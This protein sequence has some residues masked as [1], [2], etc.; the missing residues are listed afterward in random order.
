M[1]RKM[2]NKLIDFLTYIL[3]L[4]VVLFFIYKMQWFSEINGKW[5]YPKNDPRFYWQGVYGFLKGNGTF[6]DLSRGLLMVSAGC[7]LLVFS[8]ILFLRPKARLY[9][10]WFTS[11]LLSTIVFCDLI[12]FRYF[13]DLTSV[14]L[15]N[16]I[17][18]VSSLT[19]SIGE[20]FSKEELLLF[21][22]SILLIPFLVLVPLIYRK[23]EKFLSKTGLV[24]GVSLFSLGIYF[25]YY[26][27]NK[28]ITSGGGYLFEKRFS[29][30]RV[31][32]VLGLLGYHGYDIKVYAESILS[33]KKFSKEEEKNIKDLL[34]TK[35]KSRSFST[36]LKG[37]AKGKNVIIV[38][39]ESMQS[40][41]IDRSINRQ[42]ITP[43][44]NKLKNEMFWFPNIY[45]VSW[46]GRTSD[47]EFLMNTSLHPLLT[48]SVYMKHPSNT[49]DALP[50]I[51]R[52]N[53]YDTAAFHPYKGGFW[54]RNTVYNHFGFNHFYTEKDF[55]G[56]VVGWAVNDKDFFLESVE[57][58]K[59]LKKPFQA[60]MIALTN[61]HP[62]VIPEKY[63]NLNTAGY[64]E[65][66]FQNYLNGVHFVDEAVGIF[67][68]QLKKEGLWESSVVV[69]YGDH[70]NALMT[71]NGDMMKFLKS[72]SPDFN[73]VVQYKFTEG[74]PLFIHVPLQR[75]SV[76]AKTG[77]QI[78]FAPTLL[79]LLGINKNPLY[80]LGGNLLNKE[81]GQAVQRV[82]SFMND[83]YLYIAPNEGQANSSS[84]YSLKTNK[85]IN[86]SACEKDL[87]EVHQELEISDLLIQQD[88]IKQ[89][90][91]QK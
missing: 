43:H 30:E 64:N 16:Q 25:T 83:D 13:D 8:W 88:G 31:Y 28:W 47:A 19:E 11:T 59:R 21:A 68:D 67:V 86:L 69:F 40:F 42:E 73:P 49:Y 32:G 55:T 71:E 3:F 27:I 76:V 54:N 15:L 72:K 37:I 46:Q 65:K 4:F 77:S 36:P 63:K 7:V 62:Y 17:G 41:A 5:F 70:D 79:H 82:G 51:L 24:V 20:L 61:H 48:G 81:K 34:R 33:K 29:N 57:K 87:K 50:G 18:Q 56:E 26:P 23:K 66:M 35:S 74:I 10:L 22:D 1:V 12:Y 80:M 89:L 52:S 78:D 44:L 6:D 75:G 85:K 38:Q 90:N 58:M 84:C 2:K 9:T 91:Q 39:L 53:G 60:T 45:D 14:T